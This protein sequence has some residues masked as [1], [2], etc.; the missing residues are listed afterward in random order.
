M[1]DVLLYMDCLYLQE[2]LTSLGQWEG[3]SQM[4]F[5]VAKCLWER[6]KQF[7][8]TIPYTTKYRNLF[9]QQITLM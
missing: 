6:L 1:F 4:K 7:I 5:N 8:M 3:D 2:D 9:N